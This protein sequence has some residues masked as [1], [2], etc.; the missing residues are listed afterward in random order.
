VEAAGVAGAAYFN[1]GAA[2]FFNSTE[3]FFLGFYSSS[4]SSD[5][6]DEDS[7]TGAFLAGTAF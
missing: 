7:T 4:D 5:S 1:A 6:S 2:G 3:T